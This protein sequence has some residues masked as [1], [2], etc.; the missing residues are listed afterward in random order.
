MI[1]ARLKKSPNYHSSSVSEMTK[2]MEVCIEH[3]GVLIM[4]QVER[5]SMK[6]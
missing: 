4:K 5:L 3:V 2:S 1:G 6:A